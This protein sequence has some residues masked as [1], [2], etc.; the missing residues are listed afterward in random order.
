MCSFL[1]SLKPVSLPSCRALSVSGVEQDGIGHARLAAVDP[2]GRV[3]GLLD[4]GYQADVAQDPPFARYAQAA[5]IAPRPARIGAKA[6]RFG[7]DGIAFL[8]N[9]DRNVAA[10]AEREV[11]QRI[12]AIL[13]DRGAR[14]A[15]LV[16]AARII[17]AGFGVDA[18]PQH[19]AD[20][21]AGARDRTLRRALG[22]GREQRLAD[23]HRCPAMEE[24]G[25]GRDGVDHRAL[26]DL[27]GERPEK[28]FV[29]IV[30]RGDD[31]LHR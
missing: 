1:R 9:L 5:A 14:T 8:E 29:R 18:R 31:H 19:R 10:C 4:H 27:H 21:D 30:M 25:R 6:V 16:A 20:I 3:L 24:Y 15:G 23:C 28:A 17:G 2:G 26:G 12:L 13:V 11:D 7:D 22:K